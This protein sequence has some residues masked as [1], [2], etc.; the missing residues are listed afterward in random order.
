M[1]RVRDRAGLTDPVTNISLQ[2]LL[3]ERRAELAFE[4]HRL[5]DLMRLGV[6]ESVLGDFASDNGYTFSATDLLLPIPES[7]IGLSK[8]RMS[9]N[10]GY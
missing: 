4:N 10:P 5:F 2:D 7:E 9:Q 8:G 1:G 6:A 3:D